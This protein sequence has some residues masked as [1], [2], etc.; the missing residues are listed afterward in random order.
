MGLGK[1]NKCARLVGR[2]RYSSFRREA[3]LPK[4]QLCRC[5][6]SPQARWHGYLGLRPSGTPDHS[7]TLSAKPESQISHVVC[8]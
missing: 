7:V 5:I 6:E 4:A 2:H 8:R 3:Y 1:L